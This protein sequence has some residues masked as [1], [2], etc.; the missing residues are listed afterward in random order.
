MR[1]S[2]SLAQKCR[3]G[4][5]KNFRYNPYPDIIEFYLKQRGGGAKPLWKNGAKHQTFLVFRNYNGKANQSS[6]LG[7]SI[8]FSSRKSRIVEW[9][10]RRGAFPKDGTTLP[11]VISAR[12]Q[13]PLEDLSGLAI[14]ASRAKYSPTTSTI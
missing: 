14:E 12:S 8:R 11:Q 2:H 3:S 7:A 10:E 1:T 6:R 4:H 5:G 9:L 13:N